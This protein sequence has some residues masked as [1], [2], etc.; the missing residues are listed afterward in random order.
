MSWKS[1]WP[2]EI[3]IKCLSIC[4]SAGCVKIRKQLRTFVLYIFL[5]ARRNHDRRWNL[6]LSLFTHYICLLVG[7]KDKKKKLKRLQKRTCNPEIWKMS[8]S[9]M[10]FEKMQ[11]F[12]YLRQFVFFVNILCLKFIKIEL[13]KLS[14]VKKNRNNLNR[15]QCNFNVVIYKYRNQSKR[16][17]LTYWVD[18]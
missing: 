6:Q 15:L 1:F 3:K 13:W 14:E 12:F 16:S 2:F 11:K 18:Y 7:T 17:V 10:F 4:R 5:P 9:T 8:F